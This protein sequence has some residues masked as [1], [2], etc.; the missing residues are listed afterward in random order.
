MKNELPWHDIRI[1]SAGYVLS[2]QLTINRL[3]RLRDHDLWFIWTGKGTLE[4]EGNTIPAEPGLIMSFRKGWQY[5]VHFQEGVPLGMCFVHCDFLDEAG[6]V[7]DLGERSLPVHIRH[8]AE[9]EYYLLTMRRL[10][11]LFRSGDDLPMREAHSIMQ[12]LVLAQF[13]KRDEQPR[14]P[15]EAEQRQRLADT[16]QLVRESPR[17]SFNI[18]GLAQAAGYNVDYFARIFRKIHGE[19]PSRFFIRIRLQRACELLME[20]MMSIEEI[21]E[22]LGYADVFFFSRQFKQYYGIAPSMW[23]RQS[24]Q[25]F[26]L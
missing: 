1:N 12:G 14:S 2:T 11:D 3:R 18:T 6:E 13:R 20:T 21:A 24:D 25:D 16:I 10:A 19:T 4:F 26:E 15:A 9:V 23:R 5:T 17:L 7:L 22:N 8:T